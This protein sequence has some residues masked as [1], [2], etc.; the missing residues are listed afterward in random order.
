MN[1]SALRA[2]C[3]GQVPAR[4]V[5]RKGWDGL[6]FGLSV[7]VVWALVAVG[8]EPGPASAQTRP[9]IPEFTGESVYVVDE[10]D[11][12]GPLREDIKR[13]EATSPQ[14]YYVIVIRTSGPGK[15]A[16]RKYLEATVEQWKAEAARKRLKFDVKRSVVIVLAVEKREIIVLG[17]EELQERFG[18]RDPYI[19]R[20]LLQPHFYSYA[21]TGDFVRGLRVLV[22]QM[23]RWIAD[24]DTALAR[25]REEA[26]V[27]DARLQG[28]AETTLA[29]TK[30]L[31]EETRK[32]LATRKAAG[33]VVQPLEA[34]TRRAAEDID[35]ATRRLGTSAGEALQLAQQAQRDLQGVVDQLRQISARQA[36]LGDRLQGLTALS[37]QV[38]KAVEKAGR[39]GLPAAPVQRELD[40]ANKMI[41]QAGKAIQADP[42]QAEA[43]VGQADCKLRDALD[44]AGKLAEF[45]Q[46]VDQKSGAIKPLEQSAATEIERARRAGVTK[47]D[48]QKDWDKAQKLLADARTNAGSDDR[49]SLEEFN[50]AEAIMNRVTNEARARVSRHRALTRTLPLSVLGVLG[51]F[52]LATVGLL[53]LRKRHLEGMVGEQFKGFRE[54]A[55][56]LMDQLDALRH[57][58]KD[59]LTTDPD[60]SKSM[61]GSTQTLSNGVETDLNGL[62]DRWLKIMEVWDRAQ[63][64]V[65][66]GSGL[67]VKEM[68]EAKKLL[69]QEG[70]FDE[71]L[72]QVGSCKERLDRLSQSHE[73]A[74]DAL[75]AGR[76]E[77]SGLRKSLEALGE[78]GLP[79]APY[80]AEIATVERLFTQAE[81]LTGPDP[82]GAAEVI[83]RSRDV[84]K[85]VGERSGLVLTRLG[86]AKSAL[87]AI[88]EAAEVA[89]KHRA[90]GLKL[91][92]DQVNPDPRLE[93]ARAQHA[94]ALTALRR[95]DPADAG[96]RL[97]QAKALTDQAR[98]AIDR[99]LQARESCRKELPAR[100][101]A[102]RALHQAAGQA[103]AALEELRRG[104]AP[105]SWADVAGNPDR[106]RSLAGSVESVIARAEADAADTTQN[107]LRAASALAQA[108]RDQARADQLLRAV[109]ERRDALAELARQSRDVSRGLDGEIRRAE[110]FFAENRNAIGP[111]SLRSLEQA[112]RAYQE[113]AGLMAERLPNWPAIRRRID[114]VRQGTEVALRQGQEDVAG[115]HKLLQKLDQVRRKAD[116][117]GV[118]LQR[119]D[120]DRPPA[121]QRYRSAVSALRAF[122]SGSDLPAADWDRL[123]ARLN[124]IEGDLDRAQSLAHEDISL[125]KGAI[126]EISQADRAI[127]EARAYYTTGV[128]VDVSEAE[129]RIARARG[130]LA[131]QAYEQ[132]IEQA[133]SAEQAANEAYQA[134]A[135]EARLRRMQYE[136]G[137]IFSGVDAAVLIAAAQAAA[138]SAGR[139][140]DS[141]GSGGFSF[142]SFP[143]SGDWSGGWTGGADQGGWSGGGGGDWTG[144]ADQGSW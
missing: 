1:T 44:H 6:R 84:V 115:Y 11:Q 74:R 140:V 8:R 116:A 64:L 47:G 114:A 61:T 138:Q 20:D 46:E 118:M 5:S 63:K 117:V 121:N 29:S 67:A 92:E 95:G 78:A 139:W 99:Q 90:G 131:S 135:H 26:A 24:R 128:T 76:E 58:H 106:A 142:P 132:A 77:L 65:R 136:R 55:V 9:P 87:A 125:A 100:R 16:T 85:A 97:D 27:R 101:E 32:E 134:A 48:L 62:W 82:I 40:E 107:Y 94:A 144:G 124:E 10:P 45:R 108:G 73:Q 7:L 143:G 14:T 98:Q 13:L 89:A 86:E 22:G 43:L 110:S 50:S 39:E 120:K 33:L 126:S 38:L 127:R 31:L 37:G 75:K 19:E 36:D 88:D 69:E 21:R 141:S 102:A 113:L 4:V 103:D 18:F 72:K 122:Q 133:Q 104:F 56:T 112:K 105:E 96:Q 79:T 28:D 30:T 59:L 49:K 54:K 71:V 83:A 41:E 129:S 57:R 66:T 123:L 3:P 15:G 2:P 70:D 35:T 80:Q 42:N 52:A 60:F 130:A 137:Q 91:T 53:W 111:E 93:Q 51:L 34:R 23:D 25:R 12:Y 81:G 119:E 68:E 109:G 17:G